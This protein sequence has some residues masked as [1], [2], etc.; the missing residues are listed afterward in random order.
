MMLSLR[1]EWTEEEVISL[2]V[3]NVFLVE[4]GRIGCALVDEPGNLMRRDDDA[5]RLRP[6]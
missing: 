2:R 4:H 1:D 6:V 5:L 3:L